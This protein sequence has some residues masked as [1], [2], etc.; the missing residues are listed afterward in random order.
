MEQKNLYVRLSQTVKLATLQ[1]Y[2]VFQYFYCCY[3]LLNQ[4][5]VQVF[6]TL[7][8]EF[9]RK[10]F[11]SLI[12]LSFLLSERSPK[13]SNWQR[14]IIIRYIPITALLLLR[15]T[16]SH[17][18]LAL[19]P[20]V[21][22]FFRA[23]ASRG[24][25]GIKSEPIVGWVM[26]LSCPKQKLFGSTDDNHFESK[27]SSTDIRSEGVCCKEDSEKKENFLLLNF[28]LQSTLIDVQKIRKKL[29]F[30]YQYFHPY[31]I[32]RLTICLANM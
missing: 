9:F 3:F 10:F 6:D 7:L 18:I 2:S 15:A 21:S 28:E 1:T 4:K 31:Q 11:R 17:S 29:E 5:I 25:K 16:L 32:F 12:E 22:S 8:I 20:Q 13:V 27:M 30:N 26:N 14:F 24:F 23:F 19:I